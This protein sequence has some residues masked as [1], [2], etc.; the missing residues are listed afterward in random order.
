MVL[1]GCRENFVLEM[2]DLYIWLLMKCINGILRI[3]LVKLIIPFM[4]FFC[5]EMENL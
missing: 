1:F 3:V 2:I 4:L 5:I